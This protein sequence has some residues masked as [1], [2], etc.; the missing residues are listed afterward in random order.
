MH[1]KYAE[2]MTE[3]QYRVISL[4]RWVQYVHYYFPGLRLLRSAEDVCDACVTIDIELM[5]SEL[6]DKR[7]SELVLKKSMHLVAAQSQRCLMSEFVRLFVHQHNP[8]QPIL[9]PLPE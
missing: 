8:G 9:S 1:E 6:T 7:R 2:K 3:S 5:S 4:N